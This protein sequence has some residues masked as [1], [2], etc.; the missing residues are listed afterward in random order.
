MN[1]LS[2]PVKHKRILLKFSGEVLMEAD[3][4]IAS[5]KLRHF[6]QEIRPIVE[7]G[8][9]V[10]I[11]LGGGNIFR[12]LK[13]TDK[14]VNRVKG[15]Y[16]GMLATVINSI[17]LQSTLEEHQVKSRIFTAIRMEPVADFYH[18]DHAMDALSNKEVVIFSGGTGNPFFTTDTAASL[19][20]VEINADML[21]KATKVDGVFDADPFTDPNAKKYA[22]T[23]FDEVYEQQLNVMD[24][25]AFTMCRDNN[26]PVL[27]FNIT[28]PGNLKK[29]LTEENVGTFIQK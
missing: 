12:G 10:G 6:A 11:V 3:E 29:A 9:E 2:S 24:L 25:T 1:P 23:T 16:M 7:M 8:F 20:A 26:L 22:R 14:G 4:T 19:R 17:A 5:Q 18:R 21:L 27:V 13:G 28:E 15:D